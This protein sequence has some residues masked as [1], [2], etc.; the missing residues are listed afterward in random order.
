MFTRLGSDCV[1]VIMML[2]MSVV[3]GRLEWTMMSGIS[4]GGL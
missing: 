2:G 4:K 1:A 3:M